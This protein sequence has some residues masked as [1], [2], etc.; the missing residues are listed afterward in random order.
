MA[1]QGSDP[2]AVTVLLCNPWPRTPPVPRGAPSFAPASPAVYHRH[3]SGLGSA[4]QGVCTPLCFSSCNGLVRGSEGLAGL[5]GG[6]ASGSLVG[7]PPHAS[8]PPSLCQKVGSTGFHGVQ[9]TLIRCVVGVRCML[10][11]EWGQAVSGGQR[12]SP[13]KPVFAG[14]AVT[15]VVHGGRSLALRDMQ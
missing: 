1:P 15:A 12:P 10:Q 3:G 13:H 11:A 2:V 7:E 14:V 6:A 8:T 9:L 5:P 4:E